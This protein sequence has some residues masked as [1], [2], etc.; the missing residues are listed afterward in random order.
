[1]DFYQKFIS[2]KAKHKREILG[3][4]FFPRTPVLVLDLSKDSAF[5]KF[6][7]LLK[8]LDAIS[9][10]TFVIVPEGKIVDEL[11][12]NI[13]FVSPAAKDEIYAAA[14]IAVNW[15]GDK[16]ILKKNGCVAIGQ[17]DGQQTEAYNPLT[18]TGNGFYF[19]NSTKWEVFAAIVKALETYQFPYDW[20][21]LVKNLL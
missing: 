14:D 7:D 17:L 10:V 12:P 6:K 21:N 3:K 19:K 16:D 13:H 2:E 18:E 8:G 1:M 15:N 20:E 5:Q 9:V 4:M 11:G